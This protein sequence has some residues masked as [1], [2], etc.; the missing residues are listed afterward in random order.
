MSPREQPA[1]RR[2]A[3][4]LCL[5]TVAALACALPAS[6]PT[7]GPTLEPTA[8]PAQPTSPSPSAEPAAQSGEGTDVI[9]H[10]GVILTMDDARPTAS[11]IHIRGERIVSVGDEAAILAEAGPT[12]TLVDLGGRTLMPG[13]VDAHS[14]YF[15]RKDV[16]PTADQAQD[17]ALAQGITTTAEFYVDEA[18]LGELQ[19]LEASGGLRLRLSAYLAWDNGCG[20]PLGSWYLE[21]PVD[22][23]PGKRLWIN[24]VK[25][26]A[27]GGSCNVPAVSF[28]YPG[29]YGQGDL[30]F[31]AAELESLIRELDGAGYQVAIHAL[32]DRA[33]DAVLQAYTNVLHGV[34]PRRHRIEHNG[35]LR[36]DQL[37]LYSQAG[38][39]ATLL[40]PFQ[41]CVIVGDRSRFRYLVP[42]S[43]QTWEWPW[44]DLLDANPDVHFAWHADMPIFTTDVFQHL[45]GFVTRNQVAEDG[46]ICQ[47]PDW[48][49]HNALTV[50]EA[51]HLMTTGA[52]YALDRDAEVGSLVSG[53][54][55]DVIILS[56]NP[57]T[58][59]PLALK[60]LQVL[61]TM[62]GG[63]VEYCAEGMEGLCPSTAN[64]EPTPAAVSAAFR[65][66]FAAS[67][68]SQG[69]SWVREHPDAW[70]LADR[71]GWL[72][73]STGDFSMLRAGGDAPLLIRAAPGGDFELRTRVDFHP[74]QNFQFAGLVIYQD[75]D[76]FVALGRAFC[77]V[78]PPCVGDGVYLDNDEA[79]IAGVV[80][81]PA[82]GNL[83]PDEPIWLRLVR[84]GTSYSG[85]WSRDGEAWTPVGAT[86]ANFNPTGVGLMATTSAG[87]AAPATAAFDIFEITE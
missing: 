67:S 47:A 5:V 71:S 15:E 80:D 26:Y 68:L 11:A 86:V 36:P 78:V 51:L 87:G 73:L 57:R 75:D 19:T 84:Q 85:S 69:W 81:T 17:A 53:K 60:D 18:L 66:D 56:D 20:D 30:Y 7:V 55:A 44:R 1:F 2:A 58:V 16:F 6:Q 8:R 61:M 45:Y 4:A 31:S 29:G 38:V 21:H 49:A 41:T 82:A 39:V 24:G 37:P 42:E 27:D 22:R 77:G 64:V 10:N 28:E 34:N 3:L 48:L 62:V 54:Y 43:H 46:T 72:S 65:E 59:D 63:K 70:S 74:T 32:G 25:I 76:H 13:F 52:A 14:H 35:V 23:T 83:P 40:A 9:F 79:M 50:D 33:L 12:T